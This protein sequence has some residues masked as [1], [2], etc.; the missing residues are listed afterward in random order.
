[1]KGSFGKLGAA[2]LF[3]CFTLF[4]SAQQPPA[5]DKPS[6]A[7]ALARYEKLL[8]ATSDQSERFYL[9]T[10]AAPTALA[11][12]D[13]EK[14]KSYA[15]A[16]LEQAASMRD[17][18]NYGNAVHVA[19]L[20]LGRIAFSSGDVAEAGRLLLE[21]GRTPGSPQLNSFGPNMLLAKELLA[22]GEREAVVQYFDLCANFWRD[23]QGML[24]QWKAA[25]QKGVE[26][27]FGP[28]LDYQLETWRFEKWDK[29]QP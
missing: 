10:K 12:G 25:V 24:S 18:W 13:S 29:L 7:E 4:A 23:R 15:H 19:N 26:P 8:Q 27:K 1:M 6:A 16:L 17:D 11:A 20:V 22:K 3:F 14:A 5:A 28:N 21:A 2:V 9:T